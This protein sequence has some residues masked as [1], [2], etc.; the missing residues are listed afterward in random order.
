MRRHRYIRENLRA[1][2]A[3]QAELRRLQMLRLEHGDSLGIDQGD[4]TQGQGQ[5]PG[6]ETVEASQQ[7]AVGTAPQDAHRSEPGAPQVVGVVELNEGL[8]GSSGGGAVGPTNPAEALAGRDSVTG[9]EA[10]VSSPS[11]P[12][13][14]G[15]PAGFEDLRE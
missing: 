12:F 7:G 10:P 9:A 1:C 11:N 2:H 5:D 13:V 6:Q 15:Q 3:A 14:E 8:R 4:D